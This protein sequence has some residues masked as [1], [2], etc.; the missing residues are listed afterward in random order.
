MPQLNQF[1]QGYVELA[2]CCCV[3]WVYFDLNP[4]ITILIPLFH[5]LQRMITSKEC[6]RIKDEDFGSKTS[7]L[8]LKKLKNKN[9][10]RYEILE[11]L[12]DMNNILIPHA[13][14]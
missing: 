4:F 9:C 1:S 5:A 11:T 13:I 10:N 3:A 7:T 14:A 2:L 6:R 8:C 12:C